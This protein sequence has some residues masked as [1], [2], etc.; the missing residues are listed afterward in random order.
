MAIKD[1]IAG[2][3]EVPGS[4]GKHAGAADHLEGT[5]QFKLTKSN[6]A[7]RGT[8]H[9]IPVDWGVRV[10]EKVNLKKTSSET[11]RQRV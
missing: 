6:P 10:D 2:H 9:F 7:A 3:M 5:N 1:Q 8:H 11:M 4:D